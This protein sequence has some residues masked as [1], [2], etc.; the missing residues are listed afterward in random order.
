[1]M[2]IF[3]KTC[4][5]IICFAML[6]ALSGCSSG[7]HDPEAIVETYVRAVAE[8]D[9]SKAA[10][11]TS[12]DLNGRKFGEA[13][14]PIDRSSANINEFIRKCERSLLEDEGTNAIV[15]WKRS[16]PPPPPDYGLGTSRV[17]KVLLGFSTV[18]FS[19]EKEGGKWKI[20]DIDFPEL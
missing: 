15:R 20:V 1:M 3:T 9:Q 4:F 12:G 17:H 7:G 13:F 5:A 11:Y 2:R 6:L 10:K 19:L 14:L 16:I 8:G 18:D